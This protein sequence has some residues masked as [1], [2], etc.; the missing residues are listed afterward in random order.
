[1]PL[2]PPT[3]WI[4]GGTSIVG[5]NLANT[6]PAA[7]TFCNPYVRLAACSDWSRVKL[8]D[9]ED[10]GR[11]FADSTPDVLIHC[12]GVCDVAKCEADPDWAQRLNVDSMGAILN[13]L[14]D[15][16]RLVYVSSDHVFGHRDTACS[17]STNVA[18]IS[19]YGRARVA[20][21]AMVLQRSNSLVLRPGLPIGPSADG[22]SGHLDWLQYRHRQGLPITIIDD[23]FRSAAD[24]DA[25]AQRI[26]E[27]ADSV[28]TGLRHL[29]APLISRTELAESLCTKL[30]IDSPLTFASRHEQ[31]YP[32]IGRI[33]LASEH[34]DQLAEP[35]GL[36]LSW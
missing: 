18:P 23:E 32:H 2:P 8:E 36:S 1:M 16:V 30:Y 31:S 25:V 29:P 22:R 4:F 28:I 7:R 15:T 11:L 5:W 35:I 14:P 19:V 26:A 20:A 24:A 27:F 12:G 17:E 34:D 10:V 33:E 6:L 13:A 9:A 21:E 3:T